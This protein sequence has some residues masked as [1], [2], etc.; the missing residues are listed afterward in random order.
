MKLK[1]VI[2][3]LLVIIALLLFQNLSNA[4]TNEEGA[5][6]QPGDVVHVKIMTFVDADATVVANYPNVFGV[7]I[8]TKE[9]KDGKPY[10]RQINALNYGWLTSIVSRAETPY[11]KLLVEYNK[12]LVEIETLRQQLFNIKA[13]LRV[14]ILKYD[15]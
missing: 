11:T 2:G 4:I 7:T 10:T 5:T 13:D 9:M 3:I 12:L 14:L 15:I 1:C 6:L 8:D